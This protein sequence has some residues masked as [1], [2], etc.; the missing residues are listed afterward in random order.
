MNLKDQE[1]IEDLIFIIQGLDA[2]WLSEA[3]KKLKSKSTTPSKNVG[4]SR[5]AN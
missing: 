1:D 4:M 5:W 3:A 2:F